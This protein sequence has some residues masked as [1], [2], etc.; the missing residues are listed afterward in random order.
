MNNFKKLAR[1][2][3]ETSDG[4]DY[5][6]LI[7]SANVLDGVLFRIAQSSD[8]S[9]IPLTDLKDGDVII[10]DKGGEL[11][12]VVYI[13]SY[14]DS[15]WDEIKVGILEIGVDWYINPLQTIEFRGNYQVK[16]EDFLI[17]KVDGE[18][19][20]SDSEYSGYDAREHHV[21]RRIA[22]HQGRVTYIFVGNKEV[23]RENI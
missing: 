17:D 3:I 13:K 18:F 7:N 20:K 11:G 1:L 22:H 23:K 5:L 4:L 16:S 6:G 12:K 14:I 19:H 8:N 10:A 9:M 2:I 21:Y 15:I